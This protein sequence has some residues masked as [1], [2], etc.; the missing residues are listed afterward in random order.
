[1]GI[2]TQFDVRQNTFYGSWTFWC[3]L[4]DITTNMD[5]ITEFTPGF[6]GTINKFYWITGNPVTTGSRLATLNA[7]IGAVNLAGGTIALTSATVT[8]LGKV[9]NSSTITGSNN[10]GASSTISVESS[11]TTAFAEGAGMIVIGYMG[12]VV[13]DHV[14]AA[15]MQIEP[16]MAY[17]AW[18][19]KVDLNDISAAGDVITEFTPGFTGSIHKLYFVTATPASTASKAATLNVEIGSTNVVGGAV[20]LTTAGSNALGEV[21]NGTVVSG[22]ANFDKDDKISVEASSVT[23]F[24]QGKGTLV[25]QYKT[26]VK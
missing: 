19:F 16:N 17:G 14:T 6:P 13:S 2:P 23:Q 12:K 15:A 10:F 1:M 24:T 3:N 9:I 11:S 21:T 18:C 7:E 20:A 8:P 26:K 25:I 4:A 5:V 22:S